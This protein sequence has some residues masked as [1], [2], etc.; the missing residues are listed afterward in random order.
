M[1]RVAYLDLIGGAAGDMILGAFLAA[2]LPLDD[3]HDAIRMLGLEGTE[4]STRRVERADIPATK[5]AVGLPGP[6]GRKHS[7]FDS[8]A[9]PTLSEVD[10]RLAGSRLP[11]PVVLAA[12][13]TFHCLAVATSGLSGL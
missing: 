8:P 1:V 10:A 7:H 6:L 9:G 2:G 13:R 4:I 3:L 5:L 11:N 12:S